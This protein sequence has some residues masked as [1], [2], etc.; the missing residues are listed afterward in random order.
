M[1]Y[2]AGKDGKYLVV[3]DGLEGKKYD[4]IC[5]GTPF[6]SPDGRHVAYHELATQTLNTLKNRPECVI[7]YAIGLM[8]HSSTVTPEQG[9]INKLE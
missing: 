8:S 7:H 5:A 2:V 4:A 6:F 3:V 9:A 1:A